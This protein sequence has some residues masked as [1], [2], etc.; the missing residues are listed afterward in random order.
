MTQTQSVEGTKESRTRVSERSF[1]L[2]M[3]AWDRCRACV[4]T[5]PRADMSPTLLTCMRKVILRYIF[6]ISSHHDMSRLHALSL[7]VGDV[8]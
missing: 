5:C 1:F 2:Y 3:V 7:I 8:I 6:I 4:R